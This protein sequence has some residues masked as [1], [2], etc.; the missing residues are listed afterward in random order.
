MSGSTGSVEFRKKVMA[1]LPKHQR[2]EGQ[3]K[4]SIYSASNR[5]YEALVGVLSDSLSS[6]VK[7]PPKE[8]VMATASYLYDT[9]IAPIDISFVPNPIEPLFDSALKMVFVGLIGS[10]YDG[11]AKLVDEKPLPP[12]PAPPTTA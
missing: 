9:I 11:I 8:D 6:K 7:L 12:E 2:A 3:P 5:V 4:E 10:V 1:R